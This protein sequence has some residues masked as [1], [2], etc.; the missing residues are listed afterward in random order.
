[1]KKDVLITLVGTQ[2]NDGEKDKIE[3]KRKVVCTKKV[4]HTI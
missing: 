4:M 2:N 1:M 3:L